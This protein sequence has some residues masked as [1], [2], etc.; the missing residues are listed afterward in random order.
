MNKES[1]YHEKSYYEKRR[2]DK[3]FGKMIKSVKK[4]IKS[5]K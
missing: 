4:H 2:K 1:A 5:K 3:Q